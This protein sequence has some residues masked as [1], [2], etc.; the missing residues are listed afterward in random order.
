MFVR[1]HF[2]TVIDGLGAVARNQ[3]IDITGRVAI[4]LIKSGVA[5]GDIYLDALKRKAREQG[6]AVDWDLQSDAPRRPRAVV[7]AAGNSFG[8]KIATAVKARQAAGRHV[9][10]TRKQADEQAQKER[11]RYRP[12]QR[13]ERTKGE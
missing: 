9:A 8:K 2:P 10:T 13:R 5:S 4:P 3:I 11:A 6:Q 12:P 7:A 1:L